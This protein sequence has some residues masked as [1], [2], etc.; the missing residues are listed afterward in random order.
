MKRFSRKLLLFMVAFLSLSAQNSNPK[1]VEFYGSTI[2][3]DSWSDKLVES[4]ADKIDGPF[5]TVNRANQGVTFFKHSLYRDVFVMIREAGCKFSQT[6]IFT[7]DNN[8]YDSYKINYMAYPGEDSIFYSDIEISGTTR[9][10]VIGKV[11]VANLPKL[12]LGKQRF[13]TLYKNR[14]LQTPACLKGFEPTKSM[15][16]GDAVGAE[17]ISMLTTD[18]IL[19]PFNTNEIQ[20]W[21]NLE[22]IEI[23]LRYH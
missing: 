13:Y 3:N 2:G 11:F 14:E 5:A 20:N 6:I 21:N 10:A 18:C 16:G 15:I 9:A 12:P 7:T 8:H 1:F 17:W 23:L 19:L 22:D 4:N